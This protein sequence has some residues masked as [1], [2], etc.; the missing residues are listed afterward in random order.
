MVSDANDTRLQKNIS[1]TAKRTQLRGRTV[2]V[3]RAAFVAL[4]GLI[5]GFFVAGIP[6]QFQLMAGGYIGVNL[7]YNRA[8]EVV[9]QPMAGSAAAQAG[10]VAGDVLL[11]IADVPVKALTPRAEV[12]RSLLG[13]VSERIRLE[14]RQTNGEIRTFEV[15]RDARILEQ[16]GWSADAFAKYF[17]VV[18]ILVALGLVIPALF[19]FFQKSDD[20]LALFLATTLL[21]VAAGNTDQVFAF[22]LENPEWRAVIPTVSMLY[23][24]CVLLLLFVFPNGVFVPRWT[25][26]VFGIGIVWALLKQLPFQYNPLYQ[27]FYVGNLFDLSIFGVGIYAQI[28]RYRH[29]SNAVERLQTKWIVFGMA[30][31]FLGLYAYNFPPFVVPAL[32]DPSVSSLSFRVMGHAVAGFTLL[33]FSASILFS[34]QRYRLYDIDLILNRTLVYVP[35]TAILAGIFA[36]TSE[37]SKRFFLDVL[38][39]ETEATGLFATLVIV[40]AFQPIKDAIQ[41]RVDKFIKRLPDPE[42]TMEA[43]VERV[44]TRV[45]RAE[46]EPLT[47]S[48]L[49]E[50]VLGFQAE[51]GAIYRAGTAEP[52]HKA[53]GW[54]GVRVLELPILNENNRPL[55]TLVLATQRD[56]SGYSKHERAL[57]QQAVHCVAQAVEQDQGSN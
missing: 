47:R 7:A 41:K 35:L 33:V 39:G 29:L 26:I 20:W 32:Q 28:Y 31:A 43:F 8:G 14:V 13:P 1:A 25:R 45:Y 17:L 40:V 44:Q 54:N 38:G 5:V 4:L 42:K 36:V 11:R 22:G 24:V 15:T 19:I 16:M 52:V 46:F 9:M 18:D 49:E 10:I 51:G 21:V 53:R 3:A 23:N 30:V 12:Q 57:L 48:L 27:P 56:G 50:V 6:A 37:L 2:W 55:G 34:I